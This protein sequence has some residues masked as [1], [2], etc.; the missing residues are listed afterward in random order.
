MGHTRD[1]LLRNQGKINTKRNWTAR[2]IL[3]G[4]VARRKPEP[5]NVIM[6]RLG[7]TIVTGLLTLLDP[8]ITD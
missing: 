7:Q 3:E 6:A 4:R 1:P 8:S 5:V 2:S